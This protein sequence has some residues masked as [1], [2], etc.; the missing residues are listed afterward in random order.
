MKLWITMWI[1]MWI[2]KWIQWIYSDPNYKEKIFKKK[3][4]L[5]KI[6]EE[7]DEKKSKKD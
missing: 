7:E 2:D 5:Q 1:T 4:Q 3:N 6:L